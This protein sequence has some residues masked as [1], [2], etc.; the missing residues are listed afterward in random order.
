MKTRSQ[1]GVRQAREY[2][3]LLLK[4]RIRSE[5]EIYDRLKKNNFDEAVIKTAIEFLK[6]KKFINDVDFA[7]QW[8]SSRMKRL[9]G[10]RK[11]WQEL[12]AKGIGEEIIRAQLDA[13]Q[14]QYPE[15]KII[16]EVVKAKFE[17]L[18]GIDPETAK[19]RI[20][21]YLIRRGFSAQISDEVINKL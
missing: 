16:E 6:K 17:S 3:F 7:R 18:R 9:A 4:F 2:A 19:R 13:I 21:S 20:W 1:K 11:L 12:K 14:E 15:E 10:P 5:K 8:I